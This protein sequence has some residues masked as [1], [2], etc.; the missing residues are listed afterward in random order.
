ME[1]NNNNKNHAPDGCETSA[2]SMT[3]SNAFRFAEFTKPRPF[4]LLNVKRL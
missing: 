1:K 4:V 2:G 3:G